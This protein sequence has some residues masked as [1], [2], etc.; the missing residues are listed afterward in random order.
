LRKNTGVDTTKWNAV[1]FGLLSEFAI[2][3]LIPGHGAPHDGAVLVLQGAYLV[4]IKNALAYPDHEKRLAA[5]KKKYSKFVS[6][7]FTSGF[8]RSVEFI[9]DDQSSG[10]Q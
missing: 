2:R 10:S 1:N 4:R 3:S 9:R 6:I 5:L 7:P 8:D